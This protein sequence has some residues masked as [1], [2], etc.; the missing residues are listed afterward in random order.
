[1]NDAGA[2]VEEGGGGRRAVFGVGRFVWLALLAVFENI[3]LEV[4]HIPPHPPTPTPT[5][6]PAQELGELDGVLSFS[7]MA[8]PLVAR[9]TEQL[10]LPGNTPQVSELKREVGVGGIQF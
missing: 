10:G 2:G 6:G 3:Y 8:M 1:M 5:P 7:E 9:L 4:G